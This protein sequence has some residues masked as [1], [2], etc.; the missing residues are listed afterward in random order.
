LLGPET[1]V[2]AFSRTIWLKTLRGKRTPIKSA[3]LVSAVL[4]RDRQYLVPAKPCG[5]AGNQVPGR[6]AHTIAG[7]RA[8]RSG[9]GVR[10]RAG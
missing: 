5:V 3:L 10:F 2:A 1:I 9:R 4:C 7:G 8:M 6:S